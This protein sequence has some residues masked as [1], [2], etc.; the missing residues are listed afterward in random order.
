MMLKQSIAALRCVQKGKWD[1]SQFKGEAEILLD[2]PIKR[3]EF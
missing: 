1:I 3:I 2:E